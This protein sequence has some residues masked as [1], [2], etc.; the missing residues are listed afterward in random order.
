M[1]AFIAR[2]DKKDRKAEEKEKK[3]AERKKKQEAGE[4]T[5]SD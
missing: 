3:K 4:V 2:T 5:E 1:K